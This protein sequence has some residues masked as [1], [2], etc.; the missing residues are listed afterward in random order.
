[1]VVQGEIWLLE[2]PNPEAASRPHRFS[3]RGHPRPQQP[4]RRARDEHRARHPDMHSRRARRGR[5]PRQRRHLRQPRSGP[6]VRSHDSAWRT[7]RR[8]ST[9][10]VRC[11]RRSG[12][13]LI[14]PPPSS[15]AASPTAGSWA[16]GLDV[17]GRIIVSHR[18][19][20]SLG[21]GR[22]SE[23]RWPVSS[24]GCVASLPLRLWL[25]VFGTGSGRGLV[26]RSWGRGRV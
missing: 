5:R 14:G 6:Q 11:P 26:R 24:P 19:R 13:L 1:M 10:Y 8:W 3:R 12:Q 9:T 20:W 21:T 22:S 4:R 23:E 25:G 15:P 18:L 17:C 7:R 16:Y 2:T